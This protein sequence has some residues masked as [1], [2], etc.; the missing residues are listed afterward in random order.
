MLSIRA[1]SGLGLD[2]GDDEFVRAAA[3]AFAAAD[4]TV[5]PSGALEALGWWQLLEDLSAVESRTAVFALF[6]AQGRA[7]GSSVA[8]GGLMAQPYL[9]ALGTGPGSV[10]AT[11]PRLSPHRGAVAVLVGEPDGTPLLVD[12]PGSGVSV[13]GAEEVVL[14]PV[15]VPG[16]LVLHEVGLDP[17]RWQPSIT[18]AGA[19]AAR[20][21]STFLGRVAVALEILGAAEA[22][23]GLAIGH[24]EVREQFG[25]PIARFQAVRHL[26]AWAVTDCAAVERVAMEAVTLDEALPHSWGDVTKALAGRNGRRACERALQVLG[27]VGFTAD[28]AHHHFHSRVLALDALAGTSATLTRELGAL[29]RAQPEDGGTITS[30]LLRER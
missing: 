19:G 12:R 4:A 8:L 30:A 5:A 25:Q 3:Q 17:A 1:A 22:A 20:R 21:R 11:V 9:D 16:R 24:A 7:L 13:V 28:H 27:A 2:A 14:T 15:D 6:R 26:L 10:V 23:V 18:D 29:Q